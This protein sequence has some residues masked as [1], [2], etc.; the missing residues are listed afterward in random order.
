MKISQLRWKKPFQEVVSFDAHSTEKKA[1]FTIFEKYIYY[2]LFEKSYQISLKSPK[3]S[4]VASFMILQFEVI[5]ISSV[6]LK[7][8]NNQFGSKTQNMYEGIVKREGG[9]QRH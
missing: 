4:F 3:F 9:L 2:I 1:S 8:R 7:A 6:I 5:V